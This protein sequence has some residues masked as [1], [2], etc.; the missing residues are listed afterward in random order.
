MS[1]VV[2]GVIYHALED[3][4]RAKA[5]QDARQARDQAA[6]IGRQVNALQQRIARRERELSDVRGDIARQA[7]IQE[8]MRN[9]VAELRRGQELLARVQ[10]ESEER[11]Q[12]QMAEIRSNQNVLA[13]DLASLE[14]EHQRHVEDVRQG[15][16]QARTEL[17]QGLAEAERRMVATEQR[18]QGA[19]D[20]VAAGLEAER[21][22]RLDRQRTEIDRA[23]EQ[24]L[25]VEER[26]AAIAPRIS[27][28]ALDEDVMH[29]RN[30]MDR[31]ATLLQTGD[32]TQALAKAEDAFVH[33]GTLEQ[34]V[35]RRAAELE[36]AR[37][38]LESWLEHARGMIASEMV[39]RY[40][41]K[42]IGRMEP[43]LARWE[44]RARTGYAD[45]RRLEMMRGQDNDLFRRLD[46]QL[47]FMVESTP[48]IRD[49]STERKH[50]AETLLQQ[51]VELNGPPTDIKT[52]FADPND[53]KSP[54]VMVCKFGRPTIRVTIE[55]DGRMRI[56][57]YGYDS[58]G[59]CARRAEGIVA[60]LAAH[61]RLDA[62]VV[63]TVNRETPAAGQPREGIAR[64]GELDRHLQHL[65]MMS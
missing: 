47:L 64:W 25:I 38:A 57:G 49:L 48:S 54:L 61:R 15:F 53:R 62:P 42:E 34:K 60:A 10:R 16:E 2:D 21:R 4:Q 33:A 17:R 44:E 59:A 51:L 9:D 55:L 11:M 63:D 26:L 46:Q 35:I 40:F 12:A 28:L 1:W 24:I 30:L 29:I 52:E 41:A 36:A 20:Q 45:Y 3:Y 56:D 43:I 5:R 7:A 13:D 22:L 18:L 58:N 50:Q 8:M 6:A 27:A 37:D 23:R 32:S 14:A 19:I 31:A 65:E 39:R